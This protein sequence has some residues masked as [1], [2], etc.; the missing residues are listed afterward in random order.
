MSNTA[1]G[2]KIELTIND[3]ILT[4][5]KAEMV[6]RGINSTYIVNG[7]SVTANAN[8]AI[9]QFRSFLQ[10][11][12]NWCVCNC[13]NSTGSTTFTGCACNCNYACT[14]NCNWNCNCD[15]NCCD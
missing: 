3:T 2:S 12:S 6:R 9:D 7:V 5:L 1:T 8:S 13:N 11:I 4:N 10:N 15:C 14:C